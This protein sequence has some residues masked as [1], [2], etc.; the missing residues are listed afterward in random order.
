VSD[1]GALRVSVGEG[2]GGHTHSIGNLELSRK[3][4]KMA[5]RT[6]FVGGLG[7]FVAYD[8]LKAEFRK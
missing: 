6:L 4:E 5:P 1:L 7:R 2:C 8:D 3:L